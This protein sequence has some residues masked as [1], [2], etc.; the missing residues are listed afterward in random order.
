MRDFEKFLLR[1]DRQP[2]LG[3]ALL[4]VT[5]EHEGDGSEI[6]TPFTTDLRLQWAILQEIRDLREDMR[7]RTLT[8]RLQ[9]FGHWVTWRSRP[10][11]LRCQRGYQWAM[12][13]LR[14]LAHEMRAPGGS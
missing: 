5:Y 13:R 9:R 10:L 2:A 8:G 3:Q 14:N 12:K 6:D 1:V 7:R 4:S 11:R